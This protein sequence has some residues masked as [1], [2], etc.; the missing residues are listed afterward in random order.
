MLLLDSFVDEISKLANGDEPTGGRPPT[1]EAVLKFIKHNPRPSDEAFHEWA[2]SK[3]YN[4]SGAERVAYG[5]ISDLLHKG[6]S[7]GKMPSGIPEQRIA[8]GVKVEHEHT[9]NPIIARKITMDHHEE[10]GEDYYPGL[11][12]LEKALARN[13][14]K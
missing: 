12:F 10:T 11:K 8:E 3:G 5:I 9:P 6:K 13:K 2:E 14:G 4:T 1:E 7:K